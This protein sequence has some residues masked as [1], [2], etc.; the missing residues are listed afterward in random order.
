MKLVQILQSR[1]GN[2]IWRKFRR[3]E[4]DIGLHDS[5]IAIPVAVLHIRLVRAGAVLEVLKSHLV[6]RPRIR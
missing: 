5:S 6:L 1:A 4:A 2:S 3:I